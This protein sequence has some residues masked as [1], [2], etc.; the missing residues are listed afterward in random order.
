MSFV[1]VVLSYFILKA[2][3]FHH[4]GKWQGTWFWNEFRNSKLQHTENFIKQAFATQASVVSPSTYFHPPHQNLSI[5]RQIIHPP[6]RNWNSFIFPKLKNHPQTKY[7]FSNLSLNH[8][9][10]NIQHKQIKS[11][12]SIIF[13]T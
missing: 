4:V 5:K 11:K 2:I 13:N 3:L 9:M 1:D 12:K 6:P 10:L 7:S 8:V